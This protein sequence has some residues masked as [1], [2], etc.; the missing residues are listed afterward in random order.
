M[1]RF[2]YV[3]DN[4]LTHEHNRLILWTPVALGCGIAL[5]FAQKTEPALPFVLIA[6]VAPFLGLIA[7]LW[8][9]PGRSG[10]KI[11]LSAFLLVTTG[12]SLAFL[13]TYTLN[14][15]ML[16]HKMWNVTLRG[17][18]EDVAYLR[19]TPKG[20][21]KS[22]RVILR[23]EE[24]K[25]DPPLRKVRL[26]LMDDGKQPLKV[27]QHIAVRANLTPLPPP[28]WPLGYDFRRRLYFDSVGAL[29]FCWT[30]PT[31]LKDTPEAHTALQIA[32]VRS[33]LTATLAAHLA[34]PLGSVAAALLTGHTESLS[35]ALRADFAAAGMAHLLAISGLHMSIVAG[36][37]FFLMHSVLTLWMRVALFYPLHKIAAAA[38]MV[39]TLLYLHLSGCHIPALRAF[40]MTCVAM[41]AIIM[42]R[43]PLSLRLVAFAATAILVMR[44]E[45]LITP[46][47]QLSF[48]A[49][50]ALVATFEPLAFWLHSEKIRSK[51]WRWLGASLLSTLV[52]GFATLPFTAALFHQITLL[53]TLANLVA[54]PLTTF[55]IMPLGLLFS[56]AAALNLEALVAPPFSLAL[57]ALVYIAKS[58]STWPL[59][60]LSVPTG[61]PWALPV[62]TLA[63]LWIFLIQSHLRLVGF[64]PLTLGFIGLFIP[65][66]PHI[67]MDSEGKALAYFDQA[68]K[69]L[70]TSS[71]RRGGFAIGNWM[72]VTGATALKKLP[73]GMDEA[74]WTGNK[75][76][77][78]RQ[79]QSGLSILLARDNYHLPFC[80][81]AHIV[82]CL[83]PL[84]FR[85]EGRQQR[86]R[87]DRFSVW[88]EGSIA[89]WLNHPHNFY[90]RS[91]RN[92][93]GRRPWAS[94]NIQKRQKLRSSKD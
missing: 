8:F 59:A 61:A 28:T 39:G 41:L 64:I 86:L 30:S 56:V 67:F 53:G 65:H 90:V 12:F 79:T 23:L 21:Q 94:K 58:V 27:G 43:S 29:G 24:S 25:L 31:L 35:P 87:L 1:V 18:V 44:P 33:Y 74:G 92:I 6:F 14:T 66:P 46:S 47:F 52:A 2:K 10:L 49:V 3:L 7:T 63:G 71:L 20:K 13:R 34:P 16:N 32:R 88:R 81:L 55:I 69:T 15:P 68:S 75:H 4:F 91:S 26:R 89:I 62:I 76:G 93:C 19:F 22:A 78:F 72:K 5:Y 17:V 57:N 82:C 45:N 85:C 77:C 42:D 36:I 80:T 84:R 83:E 38:T 70:W 73:F 40:L 48:A 37:I 54:I 51:T 11:M 60:S 9:A 50:T